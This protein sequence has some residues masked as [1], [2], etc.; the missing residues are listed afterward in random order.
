MKSRV[1]PSA[2]C[3]SSIAAPPARS[4][5]AAR[6]APAAPRTAA[7][8]ARRAPPRR[9]PRA[10]VPPSSGQQLG[11]RVARRRRQAVGLGAAPSLAR[12]RAQRADERRVRDLRA[13]QLEALAEQHARA[14]R[15][16]PRLELAQQARL[17]DARLAA[18][19]GERRPA[20]GRALE[21][22]PS[23][24]S[25]APRPTNVGEVT[26][27][28]HVHCR[29]PTLACPAKGRPLVGGGR[30]LPGTRPPGER[31]RG[32]RSPAAS[33][34]GSGAT[35][36]EGRPCPGQRAGGA[37]RCSPPARGEPRGEARQSGERARARPRR[38][39]LRSDSGEDDV[40]EPVHGIRRYA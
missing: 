32:R 25:S 10:A 27:A 30:R 24:P 21:R 17:A 26:T 12:E 3:R 4:G 8:G 33:G 2:Q 29:A 39:R 37:V 31:G 9:A 7:P 36:G 34:R 6:A 13:A 28:R 16:R 38:G 23:M 1:E 5:R 35:E 15:A 11:Q 40:E 14:A 18:D 19:E 22:R 20:G